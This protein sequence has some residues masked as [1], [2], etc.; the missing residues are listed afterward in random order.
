MLKV[1]LQN[2]MNARNLSLRGAARQI[3]VAHTTLYRVLNG[4]PVDLST[5]NAI[6]SWLNIDA[7]TLAATEGHGDNTLASKI[8]LL[9]QRNPRL[10]EVLMQEVDALEEGTISEKDVVEVLAFIAFRRQVSDT[11]SPIS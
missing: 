5:T 8:A 10:A 11:G 2:E 1:L 3:G 6:C 4:R 7:S 9:L